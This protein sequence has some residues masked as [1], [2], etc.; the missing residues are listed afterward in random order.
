[1]HKISVSVLGAVTVL[2]LPSVSTAATP[3]Y[4]PVYVELAAGNSWV[5]TT[6]WYRYPS[7]LGNETL[8]HMHQ[9]QSYSTSVPVYSAA[10]GYQ[11][12]SYPLRADLSYYQFGTADF[13]WSPTY[14]E[15]TNHHA[16]GTVKSE[17][18]FVD[19]YYDWYNSSQFVP[20]VGVGVGQAHQHSQYNYHAYPNPN[21]FQSHGPA[22][23]DTHEFAKR[24]T[25]GFNYI[26]NDN[27]RAGMAASYMDLG[28]VKMRETSATSPGK[29][30]PY[31]VQDTA[32]TNHFTPVTLTADV[33]YWFG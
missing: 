32:K 20:Y 23:Y 26:V 29:P 7:T 11:L 33:S 2:L 8:W 24:A 17:A 3:V 28:A 25:I 19:L 6:H 18:V 10:F 15:S 5:H 21:S 16:K 14:I 13:K 1:M 22:T 31:H 12:P 4:H 9:P 27:W 30:T